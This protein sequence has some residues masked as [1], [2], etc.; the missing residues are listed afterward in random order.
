MMNDAFFSKNIPK[1][2]ENLHAF[3]SFEF[4]GQTFK[5]SEN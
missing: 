2:V 5:K 3:K 1:S 4:F